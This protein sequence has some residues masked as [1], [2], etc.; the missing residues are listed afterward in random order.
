ME[1]EESRALPWWKHNL[2]LEGI[3]WEFGS[4]QEEEDDEPVEPETLG[5]QVR[6]VDFS[7]GS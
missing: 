1:P 4:G 6:S 7:D 5:I 3:Y 2:Y